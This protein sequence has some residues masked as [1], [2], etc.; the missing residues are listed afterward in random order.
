MLSPVFFVRALGLMAALALATAGCAMNGGEGAAATGARAAS[1]QDRQFVSQA[2]PAG[3][4]E[5]ELGKLAAERASNPAVRDFGEQMV[6]HHTQAN[7]QLVDLAQ[8]YQIDV[9]K[10]LDPQHQQIRARLSQLSGPAFDEEYMKTQVKDHEQALSLYQQ[11]AKRG[12][13]DELQSLAQ[14]TTPLLQEHLTQAR[15]LQAT[16]GG[17]A[18]GGAGAQ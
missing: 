9:P 2:V 10:R 17:G 3:M 14:E 18:A 7:Q 16:V 4:A 1:A 11:Q 15:A 8:Q 13:A 12:E 5:V 6:E